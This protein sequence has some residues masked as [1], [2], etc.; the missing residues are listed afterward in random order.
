MEIEQHGDTLTL[1][2]PTI[3]SHKYIHIIQKVTSTN[4]TFYSGVFSENISSIALTTDGYYILTE[5]RLPE[6][7]T[8]GYYIQNDKIYNNGVEIS[9]E[10]L[11][12]IDVE[13]TNIL[14]T[15][16]DYLSYYYINK[17]NI[18]LIKTTFL[19]GICNC[20]CSTRE[21]NQTIDTLVMGIEVL[22]SLVDYNLYYEAQRVVEQ[23]SICTGEINSNCNCNA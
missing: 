18:D 6:I 5:I 23:L 11:L 22:K 15:D 8:V 20:G 2:S 16:S 10:D 19:K 21:G 4:T 17:Y 13:G 3:S 14:R 9:I 1:T 12:K 7:I